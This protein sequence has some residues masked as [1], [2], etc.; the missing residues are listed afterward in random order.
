M[1]TSLTGCA[2]L[3]TLALCT[4]LDGLTATLAYPIDVQV[5]L[6]SFA[7]A[8]AVDIDEILFAGGALVKGNTSLAASCAG[9]AVINFDVVIETRL[10]HAVLP[11]VDIVVIN[12]AYALGEIQ[13]IML[14]FGTG[15]A[16]LAISASITSPD[17]VLANLAIQEGALGTD[18]C[19]I[20]QIEAIAAF[21]AV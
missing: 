7:L 4:V 14:L 20:T 9:H 8:G 19:I 2:L 16:L 5:L 12:I 11:I 10:A 15:Q 6:L 13:H 17:T 1:D 18:T 21:E 3:S